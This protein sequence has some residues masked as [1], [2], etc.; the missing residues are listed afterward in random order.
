MRYV[1]CLVVGFVLG[2]SREFWWPWAVRFVSWLIREL[3][4]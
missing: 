3:A 4:K 1:V 2:V